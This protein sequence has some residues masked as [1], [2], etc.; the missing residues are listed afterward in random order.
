MISGLKVIKIGNNCVTLQF[1]VSAVVKRFPVLC[2]YCEADGL[3]CCSA[4]CKAAV[5]M[6]SQGFSLFLYHLVTHSE[7]ISITFIIGMKHRPT[8]LE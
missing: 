4:V 8:A 2:M 3:W 7:P 1:C 5:C 6:Q